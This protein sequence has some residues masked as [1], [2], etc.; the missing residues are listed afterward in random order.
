MQFLEGEKEGL[1]TFV[2][3][4][5][6]NC[7]LVKY[8][9]A[10]QEIERYEGEG[11]ID[12]DD[13]EVVTT[14]HT[15]PRNTYLWILGNNGL[16][17]LTSGTNECKVSDDM[18][19]DSH[20]KNVIPMTAISSQNSHKQMAMSICETKIQISYKEQDSQYYRSFFDT[21][22]GQGNLLPLINGQV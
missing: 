15:G 11:R 4:E 17:R 21:I 13:T 3:V 12:I 18:F 9:G 1:D 20:Y 7:D 19:G 6:A 22:V 10:F 8:N 5:E 16:A 2:V 14:L